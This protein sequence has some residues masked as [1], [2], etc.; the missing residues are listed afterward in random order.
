MKFCKWVKVGDLDRK[1]LI[2]RFR[3][4]VYFFNYKELDFFFYLKDDGEL[5]LRVFVDDVFI[6]VYC[7]LW[8]GDILLCFIIDWVYDD[9]VYFYLN[10]LFLFKSC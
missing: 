4:M 10:V 7:N 6:L 3:K 2:D 5:W 8:K 9:N 1:V